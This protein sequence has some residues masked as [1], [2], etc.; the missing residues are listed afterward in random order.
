MAFILTH[1]VNSLTLDQSNIRSSSFLSSST[2]PRCTSFNPVLRHCILN[3]SSQPHL[4]STTQNV[5]MQVVDIKKY[6]VFMPALS[7]TMTEGR[8]VQWLKQPGD[9]IEVGEPIMVVESDKADMDVE[10]FESGYLAS[11][12]IDEGQTCGVGVTVAFIVENKED[13]DRV[14]DATQSSIA[15]TVATTQSSS[16]PVQA[17]LPVDTGLAAPPAAKP[18]MAEVFMPAL[19]STMTEGKVVQWLKNEGDAIASGD[20][21]MVVESDKADMD[22]ESFDEGFLAHISVDEGSVCAV[23]EPVGYIARSKDDIPTVKAWATAQSSGATPTIGAPAADLHVAPIAETPSPPAPSVAS[24]STTPATVVNEGRIIASPRAKVVAKELGVDLRFVTGTGPNSR[25]Q[26]ADVVKAKEKG[27]G[28]GAAGSDTASKPVSGMESVVPAGKVIA[29]PEAKKIAKKEKIDINT[30][31]GTGVFGRITAH[32]VLK[33]AGKAPEPKPATKAPEPKPATTRSEASAAVAPLRENG[34]KLAEVPA[35]AKPMNAM[36]K[37]VV[38]NMNASL[39]VPVFRI[40]YK[41]KTTALDDLYAKVKSKGVTM[42]ALLAKAVA[43]TLTKHPIMN[44]QYG[45]NSIIYRPDIH[46]AMAVALNDGGLIT[47]TLK[48]ADKTDLYSMSR[49]WRDL[50]K[51]SLEK[52][53]TPDEYNSGTFIISNLGMFGVEQFDAILPPGVPGILAVAASKP[54]VG[55][56]SNGL[57]GVEKEMNVTL[58]ADHRHIYGADGAKFLKDLAEL[59]ETD[60]T[61]LLM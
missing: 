39:N 7:S 30:V 8:V 45:D 25:I 16:T 46:V 27:V 51:R 12:L 53:L 28:I 3:F 22:V 33:A 61:A 42:S 26:E 18:D 15:D 50:V 29:T 6:Q 23:G 31:T 49:Q 54:V 35:G 1:V 38:Q 47:P 20:I 2:S 5:A 17:A 9:R 32:D 36:Q 10:S 60:V 56:Q 19:S 34:N 48:D 14:K 37:A 58:T 11:I 43:I 57:I 40:T 24:I 41:I 44:A 59:I 4:R 52:K 55:L 21:V 13:I